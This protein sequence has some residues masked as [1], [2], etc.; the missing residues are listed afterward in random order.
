MING[1][2]VCSELKI[3]DFKRLFPFNSYLLNFSSK[4][5]KMVTNRKL[6]PDLSDCEGMISVYQ[7]MNAIEYSKARLPLFYTP[8]ITPISCCFALSID[9]VV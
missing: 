2:F 4:V 6:K 1:I 9:D 8:C 3:C 7:I 5:T